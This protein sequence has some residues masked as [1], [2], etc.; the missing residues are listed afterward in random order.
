MNQAP[1][2]YKKSL[3]PFYVTSGQY[4]G[5]LLYFNRVKSKKGMSPLELE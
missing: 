5:R 3:S 2:G 1:P 4:F